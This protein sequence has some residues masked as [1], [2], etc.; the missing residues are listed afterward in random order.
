MSDLRMVSPLLDNFTLE[1]TV[2]SQGGKSWYSVRHKDSGEC[3]VLKHMSIPAS[4]AQ[5]RAL[6]LSGICKDD[7]DALAYYTALVYDM[8]RELE[9]G[10]KLTETGCFAGA[11]DFQIEPKEHSIGYEVYI[12][13]E[14]QLP[15]N[16]LID[17]NGMTHL[18]AINLAI[19]LCD[20]II[21]CREAG[22]LF[23][24][25]KPENIFL[26]PSGKFLLGDMGLVALE[27]LDY[28]SI[29]DEYISA[30]SAPELSALTAN[31]N[32]T[33]DMYALGMVLYRIYNGNHNPFEDENTNEAMAN[34]LRLSG[35]PL[36]T[37]IYADYE[38]SGII[39]KACAT[40]IEN[41]FFSPEEMKEALIL[42]LQRNQ[43]P[44]SL[45]VPPLVVSDPVTITG[46]EEE[47]DS[48]EPLRMTEAE[49]LDDTFRANFAPNTS[50]LPEAEE[51]PVVE[52]APAEEVKE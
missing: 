16:E 28:A 38:L 40:R 36:P 33:V 24:N 8:K 43:I 22:Y 51:A 1:K 26:I 29:P 46:E 6:I 47:M 4:D 32:L 21:A 15:L 18:R 5:V 44:D 39:T 9:L 35:K 34:T 37:P 30:F 41:R 11:L 31:P 10:Q 7:K 42:Y 14:L 3:Y 45:I 23:L 20:A 49:E 12:L 50:I 52:E 17:R 27:D 2:M 48:E 25:I 13:Q 19:D